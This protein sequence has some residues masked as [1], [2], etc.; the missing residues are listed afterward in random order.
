[1]PKPA[2]EVTSPQKKPR[3]E[4]VI[5]REVAQSALPSPQKKPRVEKVIKREVAQSALPSPQ[6]PRVRRLTILKKGV[7]SD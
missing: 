6:K 4:K 1:M 3:V 2:A 7:H 5:K